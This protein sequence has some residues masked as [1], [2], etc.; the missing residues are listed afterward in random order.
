[1]TVPRQK[2]YSEPDPVIA[3]VNA[4]VAVELARMGYRGHLERYTALRRSGLIP[5]ADFFAAVERE[6][7]R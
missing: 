1:M 6:R 4:L 7:L 5:D 3:R 2:C